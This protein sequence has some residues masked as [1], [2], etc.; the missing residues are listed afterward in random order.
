[1]DIWFNY[2]ENLNIYLYEKSISQTM[3]INIP[4]PQ[5]NKLKVSICLK[6]RDIKISY[7]F[8]VY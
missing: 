7:L 2:Y 1:M 3:L 4:P 8:C 6:N 5:K